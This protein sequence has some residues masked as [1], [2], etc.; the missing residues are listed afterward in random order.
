MMEMMMMRTDLEDSIKYDVLVNYLLEAIKDDY[1]SIDN[2]KKL[3]KAL[4]IP[5]VEGNEK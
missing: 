5:M 3:L 4:E 1:I 2:L